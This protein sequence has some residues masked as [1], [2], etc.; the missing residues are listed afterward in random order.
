MSIYPGN[1]LSGRWQP[2]A[3]AASTL[4]V[5]AHVFGLAHRGMGSLVTSVHGADEAWLARATQ[6]LAG[7]NGRVHIVT[8]DTHKSQTG[9]GNVMPASIDGG[10]GRAGG[11]EEPGGLRGLGF[12]H[13]RSA[14]QAAPAVLAALEA[15][16][17]K[18]EY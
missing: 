1:H 13:R 5:T 7:S 6:A 3:E 18:Y 17:G 9:H 8:T 2:D 16:S 10:P 14:V 11:G 15:G 12:Y 4:R